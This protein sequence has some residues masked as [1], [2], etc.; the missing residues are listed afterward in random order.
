N[1]VY[2]GFSAHQHGG[3]VW[4]VDPDVGA[5]RFALAAEAGDAGG[6]REASLE[7]PMPGT[8]VQLRVEPGAAVAAGETLVV[9]ES[10]KMEIAIAAPRD[11]VV[12]EVFVAAGDL[13]DRGA[14]LIELVEED[15]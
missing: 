8:V 6:H 12:A 1:H 3:A 11:G 14:A 15:G 5:V 13:V 9:L 10:M 4:V 2:R 7:A